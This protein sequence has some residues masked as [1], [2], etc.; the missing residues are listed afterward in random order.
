MS[1]TVSPTAISPPELAGE[2]ELWQRLHAVLARLA[3]EIA[4]LPGY[5]EEGW[6]GKDAVAHIG[7]WMAEGAQMLRRIA[8]GT[9]VDH[10]VDVDASNV[11]FLAA[12]RG[13][14]LE[15]VH[16]QVASARAELLRAWAEL[17]DK[18]PAAAWWLHKSGPEHV[19]EHLP[20]LEEWVAELTRQAWEGATSLEK[21]SPVGVRFGH[22]NLIAA[23]WRRLAAFYTEVFRCE[24]VPPERDYHGPDLERGTGVPGA[25]LRGGHLRL[26]G[27]SSNGPTLEIYQYEQAAERPAPVANRLGFGHIA[28]AVHDVETARHSVLAHGGGTVGE[29]VT[30]RTTDGRQVTWCYVTDPEGN[31]LELQRWSSGEHTAT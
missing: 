1:T 21:S 19:A 31:I 29:V 13:L 30:L 28:F 15:T 8:A 23:D 11:R 16:L 25:A 9:Y 27:A 3:P 17:P 2:P 6:T 20:R 18:T 4:E 14:S 5:Y 24:L 10:E 7:T 12:M 22:V 26:P